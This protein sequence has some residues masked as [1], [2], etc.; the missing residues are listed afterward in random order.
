MRSSKS[1]RPLECERYF[2]NNGNVLPRAMTEVACLVALC[3]H[4]SLSTTVL[5]VSLESKLHTPQGLLCCG[6]YLEGKQDTTYIAGNKSALPH[7]LF[8]SCLSSHIIPALFLVCSPLRHLLTHSQI[9]LD[10]PL[11]DLS[12]SCYLSI[13]SLLTTQRLFT[14]SLSQYMKPKQALIS[15]IL[16]GGPQVMSL[17]LSP[18]C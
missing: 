2:Q 14:G 7:T 10:G 18:F 3:F 1:S 5:S 8:Q 9:S 15:D 16:P 11:S 6:C 4:L 12:S 17:A 13:L